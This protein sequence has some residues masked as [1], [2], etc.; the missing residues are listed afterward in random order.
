MNAAIYNFY[1]CTYYF[2]TNAYKNEG[3]IDQARFD[4]EKT[5]FISPLSIVYFMQ[6]IFKLNGVSGTILF[7]EVFWYDPN[8]FPRGRNVK[9]ETTSRLL[10]IG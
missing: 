7:V 10:W 3:V 2:Q 5:K 4:V 6:F 8:T 1:F 9:F